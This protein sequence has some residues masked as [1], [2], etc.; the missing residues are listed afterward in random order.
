MT[1]PWDQQQA[2]ADLLT[3]LELPTLPEVPTRY[4]PPVRYVLPS[5]PWISSGQGIGAWRA[6]FRVVCVV[7]PGDSAVQMTQLGDMIRAVVLALKGSRF[8]VEADAVDQPS[9]VATGS[10]VGL[11]TAINIS[12]GLSRAE[13]E[14]VPA[15]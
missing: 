10:G 4:T 3:S 11:G 14:E 15:P 13:F 12:T 2:L 8:V 6:H 5:D 7:P 9:D 1:A